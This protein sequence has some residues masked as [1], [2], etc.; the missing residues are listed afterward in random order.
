MAATAELA[1]LFRAFAAADLA[2]LQRAL[3]AARHLLSMYRR[4]LTNEK[5]RRQLQRLDRRLL[6]IASHIELLAKVEK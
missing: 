2:G 5:T 4:Q 6:D 1:S 3:R